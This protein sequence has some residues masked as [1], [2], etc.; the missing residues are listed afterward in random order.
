VSATGEGPSG[1]PAGEP[2]AP[3][4]PETSWK[5]SAT[6]ALFRGVSTAI[7]AVFCYVTTRQVPFLRE[8][9]W[10]PLAAVVVLYPDRAA[11][12]KAAVDR[13]L[14]TLIGCLVGWA[15]ALEWRGNVLFYGLAV[16][17]S[18][19]LCDVLRLE[20]ASRMCA[21]AV[22]VITIVPHHEP[23]YMV[24]LFRFVEVS[25]GIACA[26]G[27]RLS[28]DAVRRRWPHLLPS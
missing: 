13:F 10:A 18:V 14:G 3:G 2:P 23:A 8:P 12:R 11:T 25:Y 20:A 16:L 27:Y 1:P 17:V 4:S 7:V 15:S 5:A 22:T 26:M 9:Y 21:V 28:I 6:S 24:A 19:A